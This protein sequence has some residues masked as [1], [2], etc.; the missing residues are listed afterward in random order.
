M[1]KLIIVLCFSPL[2]IFGQSDSTL[3]ANTVLIGVANEI[4]ELRDTIE[5]QRELIDSLTVVHPNLIVVAKSD[6]VNAANEIRELRDSIARQDAIISEMHTQSSLQSIMLQTQ[7]NELQLMTTRADL[8][9]GIIARYQ[10]YIRKERWY[11]KSWVHITI[12]FVGALGTSVIVNNI[13]R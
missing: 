2:I 7:T 4:E 11:E 1:K 6:L 8:S 3:V 12:G 10:K 13:T 9:D 5:M